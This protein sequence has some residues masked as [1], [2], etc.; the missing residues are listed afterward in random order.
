M[1]CQLR[2]TET[3]LLQRKSFG[4]LV[5]NKG[6]SKKIKIN[7]RFFVSLKKEYF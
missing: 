7:F 4:S 1:Q 5:M 6:A 3:A 2:E